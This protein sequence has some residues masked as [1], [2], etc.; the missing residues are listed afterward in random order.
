MSLSQIYLG[1]ISLCMSVTASQT[2]I[3]RVIDREQRCPTP[4]K[5]VA[6]K[7]E[8]ERTPTQARVNANWQRGTRRCPWG[9]LCKLV[10]DSCSSRIYSRGEECIQHG[11]GSG[12]VQELLLLLLEMGET[13]PSR[14]K[15]PQR[16]LKNV[17]S[18]TLWDSQIPTGKQIPTK[19]TGH[20][21]ERGGSLKSKEGDR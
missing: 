12:C 15:T 11:G 21:G 17:R 5:P 2:P 8:R 10:S 13:S 7:C 20:C 1:H 14:W 9:V 18:D 19:L 3:R 6:G 16:T 4:E